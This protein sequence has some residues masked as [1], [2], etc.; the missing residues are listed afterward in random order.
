[1]KKLCF[2]FI[3]L[4]G[5]VLASCSPV[6]AQSSDCPSANGCVTI[7]REAAVK[8][9]TDAETVKAQA[10]E[11]LILKQAISDQKDVTEKLKIEYAEAKGENTALKQNAVSDR[12][13]IDL[14][15]KKVGKRCSPLS[16]LCL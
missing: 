7:T 13:I 3:F 15:V 8:A 5:G 10:A 1:M 9:V 12:A 2:V 11:I 16:I 6:Y 4:L 14:L